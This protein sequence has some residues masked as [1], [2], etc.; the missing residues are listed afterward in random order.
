MPKK[1]KSPKGVVNTFLFL[2]NLAGVIS[3][4]VSNF[5][6]FCQLQVSTDPANEALTQQMKDLGFKGPGFGVV[7]GKETN[8]WQKNFPDQCP[9]PPAGY[10]AENVTYKGNPMPGDWWKPVPIAMALLVF[11][12]IAILVLFRNGRR[13]LQAA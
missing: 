6:S 13:A 10:I 4:V 11:D 5:V 3:I 1:A 2:V 8:E 7:D 12:F 9:P